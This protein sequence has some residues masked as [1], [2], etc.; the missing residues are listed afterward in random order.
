MPKNQTKRESPKTTLNLSNEKMF[1]AIK[2]RA[3]DIY[4]KKGCA[5]GQDLT[6][7]LEAEKEI[8]KEFNLY[9]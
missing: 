8:K 7:W 9:R 1:E 5:T 4:C 2:K 3:Y 6:D